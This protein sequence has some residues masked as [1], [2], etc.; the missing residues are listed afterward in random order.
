MVQVSFSHVGVV[1]KDPLELERFYTKHFGF[2]RVRV[3]SRG[4]EQVVMIRNGP[5][6]LE[7]FRATEDS[8]APSPTGAGPEYPSWKHISF[9]VDNL[10][11]A[12]GA[13]GNDARVTMGPVALDDLVPGMRIAWIADPEGNI[14]ELNQGYADDRSISD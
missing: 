3:F 9:D 5:V 12:L 4:S 11:E 14:V 8:P 2:R 7:I 13:L 10:E 1:A 6:C